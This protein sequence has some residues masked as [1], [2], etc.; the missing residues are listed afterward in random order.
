MGT[1]RSNCGLR[2]S[3]TNSSSYC[4]LY[5]PCFVFTVVHAVSFIVILIFPLIFSYCSFSRLV[6]H[7]SC[8]QTELA[9]WC[10]QTVQAI[11]WWNGIVVLLKFLKVDIR[12]CIQACLIAG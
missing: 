10:M 9:T 7:C 11:R 3:R 1:S 8:G 2:F 12:Q 5:F 4:F 6:E